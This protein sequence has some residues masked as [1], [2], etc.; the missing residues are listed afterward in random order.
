MQ[1][2]TIGNNGPSRRAFLLGAASFGGLA[3]TGCST[4]IGNRQVTV[5]NLLP[6][7]ISPYYLQIYGAMPEEKFPV[8]AV[9]LN[10]VD[11]RYLRT[12]VDDPTGEK[13]G[14]IVVETSARF[15]YLVQDNGTAIRYGVGIGR[16]GF[17]W[18][19]RGSIGRKAQWPTWYPPAS[20]MERQ[21]ET[22]EFAGG[23][24]GGMNNPLGARAMYIYRNGVDTI[25]RIHGTREYWS[26]GKAVSSGC[27]R[28]I[29][30][31]VIDLYSR[32]SVGT[33]IIVRG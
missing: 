22:R 12:E 27:V 16:D 21:P 15:L 32:V 31:D 29:N 8:P 30:Q 19:G 26:I 28:L 20:M 17:T 6:A 25:Y 33:P 14:T 11:Q 10:K 2:K 23:M 5:P 13:P 4:T 9:D 18:S 3:L 1:A 24:P 7:I